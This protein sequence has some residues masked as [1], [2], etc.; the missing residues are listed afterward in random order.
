MPA[1]R[2]RRTAGVWMS[3][4]TNDWQR[5][6]DALSQQYWN[7]WNGLAASAAPPMGGASPWQQGM[8]LWTRMANPQAASAQAT[9]GRFGQQA[10]DY[11]ELMRAAGERMRQG[12]APAEIAA[13]WRDALAGA[14]GGNPMLD[15]LSTLGGD[16]VRGIQQA[17]E[18]AQALLGP[19]RAQ[20]QGLLSL[21]AFGQN[22]EQQEHLQRL[23][24]DQ[25]ALQEAY[26]RYSALLLE[27]S[28]QAFV[29][30]EKKL[31]A[32]AAEKRQ[33]ESA[34]A[35]YDLWIDAAEEAYAE[36]ALSTRFRSAYGALANAQMRVRQGVQQQVERSCSELGMPTR[37]ELDSAHRRVHELQGALRS[38]QE[39][40]DALAG[41]SAPAA[42]SGQDSGTA[43]RAGASRAAAAARAI[44][45]GPG[46]RGSGPK[47][48]GSSTAAAKRSTGAPSR[49]SG[50]KAAPS[51]GT[52][53]RAKAAAKPAARS[54]TRSATPSATKPP[55]KAAAR[56]A[57]KAT[58]RSRPALPLPRPPAARAARKG[59]RK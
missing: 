21:P 2:T 23:A 7:A 6:M 40:V 31:T 38:L 20:L 47:P 32:H 13:A 15:A 29:L 49:A 51:A 16:G 5:Q 22:R 26:N 43:R 42:T 58:A 34:R 8:D 53:G 25:A 59:A 1:L 12:A 54:A 39:R 52:R 48:R 44:S 4:S 37:A 57:S 11:L 14:G 17:A 33:L 19:G 18:A 36:T 27:A 9:A 35:L 45:P 24:R 50:A 41:G 3:D 28:Q 10:Q 46:A 55:A 56:P 30:F